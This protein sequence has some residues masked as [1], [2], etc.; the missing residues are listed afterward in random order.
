MN[1]PVIRPPLCIGIESTAHTFGASLVDSGGRIITN[2]NSTYKP[3][4]GVGIHPR[5]AAQHHVQVADDVI[6]RALRWNSGRKPYAPDI[7]AYSAG[8]GLGP[9]LRIGATVARALFNHSSKTLVL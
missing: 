5:K 9:C 6:R 8:P 3:P 1:A 7:I 4:D 2:V